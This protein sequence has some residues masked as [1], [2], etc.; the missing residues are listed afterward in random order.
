MSKACKKTQKY[1][2]SQTENIKKSPLICSSEMP[3]VSLE[4]LKTNTVFEIKRYTCKIV[5]NKAFYVKH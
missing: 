1:N 5:E 2:I 4:N 3:Y